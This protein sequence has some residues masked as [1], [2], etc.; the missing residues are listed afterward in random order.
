MVELVRWSE[1]GVARVNELPETDDLQSRAIALLLAAGTDAA[2]GAALDLLADHP[3]VFVG[4]RRAR[5][6]R[7]A[8]TVQ[9]IAERDGADEVASGEGLS[10]ALAV[11]TEIFAAGELPSRLMGGVVVRVEA[12]EAEATPLVLIAPVRTTAEV[13]L[14]R[15]AAAP[16]VAPASVLPRLVET[17]RGVGLEPSV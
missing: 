11:G 9:L 7:Q 15:L 2:L 12:G 17:L 13:L 5:V 3:H 4:A 1:R 10:L 14:G 8:L 6:L 16:A